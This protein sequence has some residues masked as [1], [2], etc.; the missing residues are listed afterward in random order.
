MT[1]FL[2][3]QSVYYLKDK[4][5]THLSPKYQTAGS[6]ANADNLDF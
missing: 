5:K 2:S 6:V 1:I 4:L 3:K